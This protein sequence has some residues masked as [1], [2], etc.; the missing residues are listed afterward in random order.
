VAVEVIDGRREAELAFRAVVCSM[1]DLGRGE[2]LVFDVGGGST[3]LVSGAGGA[4]RELASVPIGAVRLSERFLAGDPPRPDEVR[5]MIAAIDAALAGAP[6]PAGVPLVGTAGT[7]TTLAAVA[8]GLA[9]Y[10]PDRVQGMRVARAE[11]ERQLARYLELTVA[12]R[13]RIPGLEPKRADTI[14]AG[15]AIV[16]RV[17][18]RAGADGFVVSDRGVRWGLAYE[19]LGG[20]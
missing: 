6:V 19:L 20:A 18:D 10:D 3:E 1:P 11:V 14:P 17:L 16:A 7:A 8:L 5:A 4:V 2:L 9:R 13:R 15:A 12:E